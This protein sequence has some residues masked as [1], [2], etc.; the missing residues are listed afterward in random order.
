MADYKPL[1]LLIFSSPKVISH[2]PTELTYPRLLEVAD[3]MT[4]DKKATVERYN[5][6]QM[7]LI[8]IRM[9]IQSIDAELLQ[10]DVLEK[11]SKQTEQFNTRALIDLSPSVNELTT[12]S[13]TSIQEDVISMFEN[14]TMEQIRSSMKNVSI[15]HD[16]SEIISRQPS[17]T[18]SVTSSGVIDSA[19]SCEEAPDWSPNHTLSIYQCRDDYF[20]QIAPSHLLSPPVTV[21]TTTSSATPQNLSDLIDLTPTSQKSQIANQPPAKNNN[22]LLVVTNDKSSHG[23]ILLKQKFENLDRNLI[24]MSNSPTLNSNYINKTTLNVSINSIFGS[25]TTSIP[26]QPVVNDSTSN[27]KTNV[28]NKSVNYTKFSN[29]LNNV[30]IYTLLSMRIDEIAMKFDTPLSK[31]NSMTPLEL[32]TYLHE[33]VENNKPAVNQDQTQST[34]IMKRWQDNSAAVKTVKDMSQVHVTQ[35]TAT[36]K[37]K[38]NAI[39]GILNPVTVTREQSSYQERTATEI[40][41]NRNMPTRVMGQ[42]VHRHQDT[43]DDDGRLQKPP[44]NCK[45]KTRYSNQYKFREIEATH[46]NNGREKIRFY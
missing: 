8:E 5:C 22:C 42:G 28:P 32:N 10:L 3:G 13:V 9:K 30:T 20:E 29:T 6:T 4:P 21:V 31:L 15:V 7:K 39:N 18:V 45:I 14:P 19:T 23:S 12:S 11:S 46:T 44:I 37:N 33:L 24:L 16:D 35:F 36:C 2:E 1:E 40:Q 26:P 38:Q 17:Q 43:L 27:S 34:V 41:S 25:K